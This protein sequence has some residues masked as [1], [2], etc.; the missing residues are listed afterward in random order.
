MRNHGPMIDETPAAD[1][2][3][4]D[5]VEL[6][7][8]HG[9]SGELVLRRRGDH[10]EIVANGVFLMDTRDGRSERLLVEAAAARIPQ[11]GRLVIGGLGV[12]F[13]LAAAL[14]Q[15]R[16]REIVVVELE[17]AVIA[18]NRGPLAHRHG[19]A[20][21]DPRVRVVE[22]DIGDWLAATP[23]D[24]VDALCLD[25]DNGPDWLVTPANAAL[26]SV[27]GVRAAVRVLAPGGVLAYWSAHRCDALAERMAGQL[28]DVSSFEVPVRRGEPDVVVVGSRPV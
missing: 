19:D 16:V 6:D 12:G 26:Y 14:A 5:V 21:R 4:D 3:S 22:A 24:S 25:V 27:D 2:P 1:H 20:L 15:Q 10:H 11:R 8:T 23:D 17:P 28:S 9:R 7:R 13:S 18:W